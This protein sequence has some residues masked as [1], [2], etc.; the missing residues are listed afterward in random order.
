VAPRK[1]P[2]GGGRRPR[3]TE[4]PAHHGTGPRQ[5]LREQPSGQPAWLLPAL[6][7]VVAVGVIAFFVIQSSGGPD[8]VKLVQA[9]GEAANRGDYEAAI[10]AYSTVPTDSHLYARAQAGLKEAIEQRDTLASGERRLAADTLYQVVRSIK[11]DWIERFGPSGTHYAEHTRYLLKRSKEFLESF[12]D[13]S[14]GAELRGYPEH[15]RNVASL[16]RP[17]TTRDVSVEVEWRAQSYEYREGVAA[18]DEFA[19]LPG[20]APEAVEA[21]RAELKEYAEAEWK[22]FV[23]PRLERNGAFEAGNENWRQIRDV[24]A[25][26]LATVAPVAGVGDEARELNAQAV[27]ALA[28]AGG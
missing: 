6:G 28:A 13:D 23:K 3:T 24:T 16:D 12:P 26:Y 27:A 20:V 10:Q 22:N 8:A 17:P 2:G 25:N 7:A 5:H 14:R 11:K 1:A 18:I 9:G 15:F 4:G 19:A 21:L